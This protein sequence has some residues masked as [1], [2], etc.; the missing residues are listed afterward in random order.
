LSKTSSRRIAGSVCCFSL[1]FTLATFCAFPLTAE[2]NADEENLVVG[3]EVGNIAPGFAATD[4]DGKTVDLEQVADASEFI[5]LD[6]WASW[7]GPC[8]AE[9]PHLRKLHRQYGG[10]GLQI[11]G[12]CSDTN[13]DTAARAA[14]QA[15]LNY[16]HV[17]HA[18]ESE[19][20]ITDLYK[21]T[22]IPQTYLLDKNLRI[23][24]K[25]L[26]GTS[27]EHRVEELF[28]QVNLVGLKP[29]DTI[30]VAKE[31]AP[32][33]IENDVL[34]KL[35][36]GEK[37]RVLGTQGDWIWTFVEKEGKRTKGWIH[38]KAIARA[39]EAEQAEQENAEGGTTAPPAPAFPEPAD[40]ERKNPDEMPRVFEFAGTRNLD[41]DLADEA[42]GEIGRFQLTGTAMSC[43]AVS[44]DGRFVV[45]GSEDAM[46]RLWDTTTGGEVRR[47]HGHDSEI[48]SL[49]FSGDGR[50]VLSGSSDTTVRLWD[51]ATGKE[52]HRF[53]GHEADVISVAF[54]PG[55]QFATSTGRDK[56]L[57]MWKLPA[58]MMLS[59][60]KARE[61]KD[62]ASKP[63]LSK[64]MLTKPRS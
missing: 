61:D 36:K 11:I 14:E 17:Y 60:L 31:N 40:W 20:S 28:S 47:F 26:R 57:R 10:S 64:P 49:A 25:G 59:R 29:N 32:L 34:A 19:E 39:T 1:I 18:N 46:I 22:G 54:A 63:A 23:V 8:R 38:S 55:E 53:N 13:R 30:V 37:L 6:F 51:V 48:L 35:N 5:L 7:C 24:A 12:V 33:K 42:V 56:T 43:A 2:L 58:G 27:L 16:P 9:F 45:S 3:L 52:L 41:S 62:V 4:L 44:P 15:E 50:L 21:V